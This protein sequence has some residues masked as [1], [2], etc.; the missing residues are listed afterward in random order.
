MLAC[1]LRDLDFLSDGTGKVHFL[2]DIFN[3]TA[4]W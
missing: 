1:V 2:D 3:R 4:D